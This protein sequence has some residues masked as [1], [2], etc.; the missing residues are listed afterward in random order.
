[1]QGRTVDEA[2]LRLRRRQHL[3]DD[4]HRALLRLRQPG[5]EVLLQVSH[6]EESQGVFFGYDDRKSFR[7]KTMCSTGNQHLY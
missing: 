3:D 2:V 7:A 1:M 6:L 5:D 4:L